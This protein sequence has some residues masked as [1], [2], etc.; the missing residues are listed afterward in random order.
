LNQ[1]VPEIVFSGHSGETEMHFHARNIFLGILSGFCVVA[2]PC[3]TMVSSVK[4]DMAVGLE[5]F[6]V[7]DYQR[8]YREFE[9]AWKTGDP[10][11]AYNI[12]LM[13]DG[14]YGVPNSRME[15][16]KWYQIAADRGVADA[17]NLLAIR[18]MRG[19]GVHK[20]TH[21]ALTLFFRAASKGHAPARFSLG[22]LYYSGQGPLKTDV[23]KAI[24]LFTDSANSGHPPA[25]FALGKLLLEDEFVEVDKIAAWQWLMLAS[26]GGQN[27]ARRALDKLTP[28]MTSLQLS[29]ARAALAA[30]RRASK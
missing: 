9:D 14:G 29:N 22:A 19:V 23:P 7:K 17:M 20:D 30:T 3:L 1:A 5:A 11:A 28:E 2:L 10:N 21:K 4:A 12:G 18:Y 26:E 15:A 16:A 25:Q 27:D 6:A 13:H 24:Q 8:A